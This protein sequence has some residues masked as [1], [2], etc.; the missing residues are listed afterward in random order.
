MTIHELK[1]RLVY[2]FR[3]DDFTGDLREEM[4]LHVE[5]RARKL[6][7]Q[8]IDPADAPYA[9]QRQFGNR[10]AIQ[11]ASAEQWGWTSF[12]RLAQ[13]VRLASRVL[14]KSPGF[15]VFAIATLALGLGVNTAIFTIVDH[16]M[17]R[18][19]PYPEPQ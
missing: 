10:A 18:S 11:D 9:A 1:R 16:V 14:R 19:L 2:L 6:E 3:R 15:T 17:L 7:A 12:E 8:G 13:D 4:R 5:L